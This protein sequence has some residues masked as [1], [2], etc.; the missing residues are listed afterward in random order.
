MYQG[1]V[2]SLSW[3]LRFEG[4]RVKYHDTSEQWATRFSAEIL[5]QGQLDIFFKRTKFGI[6]WILLWILLNWFSGK[7][8]LIFPVDVSNV[9]LMFVRSIGIFR[10]GLISVLLG[11]YGCLIQSFGSFL[12]WDNNL[13]ASNFWK[14]IGRARIQQ[15]ELC[16]AARFKKLLENVMLISIIFFIIVSQYD[17]VT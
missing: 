7:Y 14:K 16:L 1:I 8:T 4:S 12:G 2:I 13:L 17:M 3:I 10:N 6:I 5:T 11:N 9:I 15:I